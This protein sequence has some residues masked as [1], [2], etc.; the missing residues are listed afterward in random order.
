M[1]QREVGSHAEE[2]PPLRESS[3]KVEDGEAENPCTANMSAESNT[4][5]PDP[6]PTKAPPLRR[7]SASLRAW[8]TLL[9]SAILALA[10]DLG[11]KHA[12]FDRIA[13]QPVRVTREQVLEA[14]PHRLHT[15]IPTHAPVVVVPELLNLQLVLNAGAVFGA[16]QG[17]RWVFVLFTFVALGFCL[18]MF[19][20]WTDRRDHLSHVCIGL[21]LAGGLGNLY[22][23]LIFACVR[24]FLHP[25]PNARLPFGLHWPSGDNALWPY[26]SNVADAFLIIG[27]ALLMLR[28][29]RTPAQLSSPTT[30]CP[31]SRPAPPPPSAPS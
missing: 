23:R 28:L 15:L 17:K 14:G 5:N 12:A 25:L 30:S 7:S 22:D 24:D 11:T 29:W 19:A 26:V 6:T 16:G 8:I 13:D 1:H 10:A 20:R 18:W 9:L 27:I 21:I 3:S 2:K 4:H 31:R